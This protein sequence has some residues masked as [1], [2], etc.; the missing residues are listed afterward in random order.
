MVPGRGG[1]VELQWAAVTSASPRLPV[2]FLVGLLLAAA[3]GAFALAT[4]EGLA[5]STAFRARVA[6]GLAPALAGALAGFHPGVGRGLASWPPRRVATLAAGLTAWT[7]VVPALRFDPYVAAIVVAAAAACVLA[8]THDA[9]GERLTG[10]MALGWLLLWIPFDLRWYK[11]LWL[12]PGDV[13]YAALALL[14]TALAF[15]AFGVAGRG[16]DLGL[17]PPRAA[18]LGWSLVLWVAFGALALPI[19]FAT[20]F[21]SFDGAFAMGPTEALLTTLGLALTVALPEEL[22]FRG[23]LDRGL[24]RRLGPAAS[25]AASSLA[26]GLMHWNNRSDPGEQVAYLALASVAGVFYGL[27]FRK[28]RGLFAPVLVHT[29]TDLV[30]KLLLE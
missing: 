6:L 24:A 5:G 23:V 29:L 10:V 4:W 16:G 25:L 19:G 18:D 28:T 1:P 9:P 14:V 11:G 20:G 17:R 30:W 21:L 26:F 15:L 3:A 22:F 7:F 13:A 12:G 27:A 2:A 8:Q